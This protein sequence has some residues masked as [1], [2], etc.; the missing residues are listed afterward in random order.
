MAG[1]YDSSRLALCRRLGFLASEPCLAG[2]TGPVSLEP[3][4]GVCE[5]T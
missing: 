5:E 1:E 2:E 4:R 3:G